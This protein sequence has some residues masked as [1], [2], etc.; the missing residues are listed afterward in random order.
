MGLNILLVDD[1]RVVRAV[2]A[3][4]L[5]LS[6]VAVTALHEA[7]DG[8]EALAV[9]EKEAVDLVF[10][11]LMMPRMD[12]ERLLAEMQRRGLAARIP[13]VVISSAGGA[14]RERL[15]REAGARAFLRKPFTPEEVLAVVQRLVGEVTL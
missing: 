1:S 15:L 10:T 7:G 14:P 12:G 13:V 9:L 2:L 3:R 5:E 4:A 8:E 11:D 6:G